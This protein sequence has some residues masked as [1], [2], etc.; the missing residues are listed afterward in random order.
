[1]GAIAFPAAALCA[2]WPLPAHAD[3]APAWPDNFVARVE[4]L[5]LIQTLN[6]D[7]LASRSATRSLEQWCADHRLA[8]TPKIVA[9]RVEGAATPASGETRARLQVGASET[10]KYRKVE[11]RCGEQVLSIAENWYVP[12]R[13]D[14]DANRLLES[15]DTP[16]GKVVQPLQPYRQTFEVKL[17]WSPLPTGWELEVPSESHPAGSAELQIP[18]ALFEHRAVLYSNAHQPIAEVDE[19]YQRALLA[20]P[21]PRTAQ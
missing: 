4:A 18:A 13:L 15:T 2:A 10:V 11:L 20:F 8:V 1:M 9:Q 12:G 21:P 5:A 19:V 7:I 3:P 14:P 16:F 17:L 6:T